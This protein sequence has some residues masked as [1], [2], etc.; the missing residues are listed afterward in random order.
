M[1]NTIGDLKDEIIVRAGITTTVSG[2]Y[3]DTI[4]NDWLD[5]AHHWAAAYHKWP[6]TEQRD[7]TL[8]FSTE[9]IPYS[10]F[11]VSFKADSIRFLQIGGKRL[12]KLG[13]SDYQIFREESSSGTDRVYSDFHRTLYIN[14]NIDVS[15]TI[16]AYGQYVPANFDVTDLTATTVFS[17]YDDDGNEAI[18]QEMLGYAKF[19]EK[20][21]QEAQLHHQKAV[22]MLDQM[23]KRI[24]DEQ[25][26]YQ[27]SK[28][29]GGMFERFDVLEGWLEDE[30]FRRDQF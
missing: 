30:S 6:F 24:L 1:L 20:K 19:R 29:R 21:P 7:K 3:T 25:H 4:V 27:T 12:K 28:E 22:E 8:A 18:L 11:T 5:Q 23:W 17:T 26:A 13:F 9:E 10:S 2:L 15:G 16:T 14:P